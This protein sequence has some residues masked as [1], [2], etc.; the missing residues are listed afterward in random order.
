MIGLYR[1]G[2]SLLHRLPAGTKLLLLLA[3]IILAT[4]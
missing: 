3:S 1:P 2:N 4:I